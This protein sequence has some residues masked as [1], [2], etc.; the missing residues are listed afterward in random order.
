MAH[1]QGGGLVDEARSKLPDGAIVNCEIVVHQYLA[2][3]TGEMC[4]SVFYDGEI[5]LSQCLGLLELA[6]IDLVNRCG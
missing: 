3:D 6:K 2:P 4:Y 1:L 5:P